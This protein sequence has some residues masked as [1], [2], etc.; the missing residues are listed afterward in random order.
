MPTPIAQI[1]PVP[2]EDVSADAIASPVKPGAGA[3]LAAFSMIRDSLRLL[4]AFAWGKEG[5][6]SNNKSAQLC[7]LMNAWN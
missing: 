2:A 7:D 3:P 1:H 6:L 5:R 4:G